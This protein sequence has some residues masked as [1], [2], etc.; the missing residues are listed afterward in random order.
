[1]TSPRA[2][3]RV[4]G[5]WVVAGGAVWLVLA[6]SISLESGRQ[7]IAQAGG[8]TLLGALT[9]VL[10]TVSLRGAARSV[11]VGV[12]LLRRYVRDRR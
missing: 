5:W 9:L 1:M 8:I 2:P 4:C 6:C 10:L 11:R 3:R 7:G 12:R